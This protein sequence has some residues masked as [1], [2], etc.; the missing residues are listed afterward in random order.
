MSLDFDELEAIIAVVDHGSFK[1]AATKL[2]KAQSSISYAIKNL[3]ARLKLKIFERTGN[4][5]QLTNFGK[6]V[7]NKALSIIRINSDLFQITNIV[8]EGVELKIRLAISAVTPLPL[9]IKVLKDFNSK[10]PQTE[11]EID[12]KTFEEPYE[13]LLSGEADLAI[14][15]SQ[16]YKNNFEA[17]PWTI[18]E[19]IPCAAPNYPATLPGIVESDL[20]DLQQLVVGGRA[21]LAKKNAPA[22][23]NNS[24][25]W[26]LTDFLIKKE[27]LINSLGWGYMPKNLIT[28][29]LDEGILIPL[30]IKDPMLKQLNLLRNAV[31]A[32]GPATNYLWNLFLNHS[33]LK[34]MCN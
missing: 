34:L 11:I 18:V 25:V 17:I 13:M 32:K 6:I 5:V 16:V 14:T 30:T 15:V 10:F 3:E 27:L 29:E 8:Q 23:V 9:L 26:H 2:H 19:M 22:R 20:D 28:R 21:T 33:D 1:A 4:T 24:K 12:F 7:Y 31:E